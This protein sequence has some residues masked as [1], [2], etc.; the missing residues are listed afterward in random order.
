MAALVSGS[1]DPNLALESVGFGSR[2]EKVSGSLIWWSPCHELLVVHFRRVY[3]G[4]P[5]L[6]YPPT[7]HSVLLNPWVNTPYIPK[8]Q[9]RK[10]PA[11]PRK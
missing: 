10:P 1:P 3:L 5:C 2:P 8:T 6:R 7:V 11:V 4:L 9:L